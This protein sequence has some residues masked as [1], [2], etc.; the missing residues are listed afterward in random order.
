MSVD[1][2][3]KTKRSSISC[4]KA[5][6]DI[7]CDVIESDNGMITSIVGV[8]ETIGVDEVGQLQGDVAGEV[9][10]RGGV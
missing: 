4:L 7:S 8:V 10:D 2:F 5:A 9:E 6:E 1:T 3:L